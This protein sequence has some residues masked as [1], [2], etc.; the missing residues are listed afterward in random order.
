MI[1]EINTAYCSRCKEFVPIFNAE[2][3]NFSSTEINCS[4]CGKILFVI[5]SEVQFG[6]DNENN[7]EELENFIRKENIKTAKNTKQKKYVVKSNAL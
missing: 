5:R 4:A 6:I 7:M 3:V 2:N 1:I